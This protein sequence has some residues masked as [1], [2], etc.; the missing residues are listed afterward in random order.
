M[1]NKKEWSKD[2]KELTRDILERIDVV[3]FSFDISGKNKGC[4]IKTSRW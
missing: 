4:T 1:N 2:Q 3:A